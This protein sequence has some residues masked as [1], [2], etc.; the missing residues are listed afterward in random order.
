MPQY[1]GRNPLKDPQVRANLEATRI[2]AERG[3]IPATLEPE[4]DSTD[5][6]TSTSEAHQTEA[7]R[8]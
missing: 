4:D 3:L 2:L 7:R 1:T 8:A 5:V 6:N